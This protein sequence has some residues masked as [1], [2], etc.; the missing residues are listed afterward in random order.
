MSDLPTRRAGRLRKPSWRDT[1][2]LAGVLLVL[3][4]AVLGAVLVARA[5]DRVP[6]YAASV[7]LV[8]GQRLDDAAVRRV[9]VQLGDGMARYLPADEAL[10][11]G[12]YVLRDVRPGELVPRSALGS[13]ADVSVQ[14]VTID[15]DA[16]SASTLVRGSVVDVYVTPPKPGSTTEFDKPVRALSGV[17]VASEPEERTGFG[18]SGTDTVAVSVMAPQEQVAGIVAHLGDRSRITVVP[19][20]GSR[21]KAAS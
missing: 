6:V 15:V 4:S 12:S 10:P 13:V 18:A 11:E 5:D 20:P 3:V 9:E 7:A 16:T 21:T 17:S 14:P 1:R 2:L 8:P 19:V